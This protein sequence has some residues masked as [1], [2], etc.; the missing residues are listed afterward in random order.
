M[1]LVTKMFTVGMLSTNCYVSFCS[2]T[3]EAVVID[4]GLG[5]ESEVA[6]VAAFV[7]SKGLKV[8]SIVDTHGH[9]DHTCGNGA[10][11][12]VFKV[13]ICI[14]EDDA[15]MLG[16]SGRDTARY[17]GF[18]CVSPSADVFLHDGDLVKFGN[19]ALKVVH[20]PG[21]SAGS[22]MLVGEKEVFT[23]DTLFA[24]SIG[25]TDFPGSSEGAMMLSLRKLMDLPDGF[26]VY[27]GHGPASSMGVER[28]VN[29]FL[30]GL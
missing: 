6:E 13:P 12:K 4:P 24:G 26:V 28:R 15:Y 18:D 5:D 17:F 20:S 23:G 1:V 14:H 21:H 9:P 8:K 3:L 16:E 19:C 7:E 22:M 11:K 30:Q 29:P 10:V 25:R 27:P 2:E